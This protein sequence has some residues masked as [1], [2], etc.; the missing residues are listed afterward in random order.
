M[1]GEPFSH[2]RAQPTERETPA[3]IA[4]FDLVPMP[5]MWTRVRLGAA[6]FVTA[7]RIQEAD[8]S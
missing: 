7:G 1:L 4:R 8:K 6:S 5:P 3:P 2:T